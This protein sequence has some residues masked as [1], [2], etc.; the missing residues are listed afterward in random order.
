MA[1]SKEWEKM[2]R[3]ELYWAGNSQLQDNRTRCRLACR[4]FNESGEVSRRRK[5]EL[6]RSIIG[7]KRPLPPEN[8]DPKV[9][10]ALFQD[11]DPFVDGP[12]S[13][14]HGLNFRVGKGTFLNFNLLVLDT[15]SITIGENV[16]FGP[17]VCLYGAIHPIDPAIRRGVKGPEAGKEIH[18]E[19]DVWIGGSVLILGGDVPPFHF[20]AGNPARVI[21]RIETEMDPEYDGNKY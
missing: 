16:L 9:D 3:G 8:S 2:L 20:A 5:V 11:T 13:V 19:D 18:I 6:W 17:N 7:D 1:A 10:E 12:I 4:Q 14:D 15:C 21:R